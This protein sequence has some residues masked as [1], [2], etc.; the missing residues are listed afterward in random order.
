MLDRLSELRARTYVSPLGFASIHFGSGDID[1]ALNLIERAVAE[2]DLVADVHEGRR[3]D[4]CFR[5]RRSEQV[6]GQPLGRLRADPRQPR[7]RF[8][9]AG[10]RLDQ[11]GCHVAAGT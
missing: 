6:I 8:D 11:R 10:D 3:E 7:E 1:H 2:H 4:A 5:I 9:Q